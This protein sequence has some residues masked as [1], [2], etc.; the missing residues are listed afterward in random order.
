MKNSLLLLSIIIPSITLSSTINQKQTA[1]LIQEQIESN[2]KLTRETWHFVPF[3]SLALPVGLSLLTAERLQ[4]NDFAGA[5]I[6]SIGTLYTA[7]FAR[8][9]YNADKKIEQ[10]RLEQIERLIKE[11]AQLEKNETV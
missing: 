1:K 11:Q 3:V 8:D 5:S 7:L 4:K 2:H 6:T 9:L 10:E